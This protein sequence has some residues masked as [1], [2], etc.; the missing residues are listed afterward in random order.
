MSRNLFPRLLVVRVGIVSMRLC[1]RPIQK[2]LG[3]GR[4][5]YPPTPRIQFLE[6]KMCSY[7]THSQGI[8]KSRNND[9]DSNDKNEHDD[10]RTRQSRKKEKKILEPL[11]CRRVKFSPLVLRKQGH[12]STKHASH[13][14]FLQVQGARAT[15]SYFLP[16]PPKSEAVLL[17]SAMI[18]APGSE[19]LFA[20]STAAVAPIFPTFS[21]PV[22]PS[23]YTAFL[24]QSRRV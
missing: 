6:N 4:E 14:H 10:S 7:R 19:S 20:T 21:E 3:L 11:I 23:P 16:P 15:F 24:L 5:M 9:N 17:S 22:V 12:R 18:A 8:F 1:A 13:R 2:L